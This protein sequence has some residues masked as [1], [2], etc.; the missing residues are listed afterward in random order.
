MLSRHIL[1]SCVC[2]S[3][4]LSVTSRYRRTYRND[5]T[6]R[7]G[8]GVQAYFHLSYAV[9]IRKPST[10]KDNGTSLQNFVPNSGLNILPRHVDRVVNETRRWSSLLIMPTTVDASWLFKAKFDYTGPT[11]PARTLSETRTDPTEFLGDPGRKKVRAGPV[12]PV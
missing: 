9:Y 2:P 12:G 5:W 7:A 6:Y 10:C 8:F 4:R 1:S 3:P 11:G